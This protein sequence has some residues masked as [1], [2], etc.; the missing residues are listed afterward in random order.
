MPLSSTHY[1]YQ[2][3]H[4]QFTCYLWNL[5]TNDRNILSLVINEVIK[6]VKKL[7]LAKAGFKSNTFC[8]QAKSS[9]F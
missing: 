9:I 4:L 6:F 5:I 1:A 8:S 7:K 2:N 3:K